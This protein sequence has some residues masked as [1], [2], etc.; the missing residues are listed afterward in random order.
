MDVHAMNADQGRICVEHDG[1]T[2]VI[3][4]DRPAARN[5]LTPEMH[6]ALGQAFDAFA[7]DPDQWIA[8]ITGAGDKAFSAGSDLKRA[9][10]AAAPPGPS[11][12]SGG[13]GGLAA[14][15]D[16]TKPVIAAVNGVAVGGG[17][18]I[19]LACDII[20]AA[21]T[22]SFGLPEP[23]VG[24]AAI[25]GGLH[26]LPRQ[27]GYKKAM[28]L[29]LTGARVG[30]V[31]GERLGFVNEVVPATEL[32][33][34]ARRWADAILV[35]SP[36]A[37]RASKDVVRRGLEHADL[38]AALA[39]QPNTPGLVAMWASADYREGPRAFA[40]KRKPRWCGQ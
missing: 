5:A 17:F 3:T 10:A 31:E 1:R 34:A 19:A 9:A 40:E 11:P 22:A 18:E 16:L 28:G 32:M 37:V 21:D 39:D 30:A 13:Y 8:I 23:A 35:N 7:A 15:F 26:R 6:Q 12:W 14:R 38:A 33:A 24:V 20:I 25:G 29:I 36:M 2:T 4:I 27:I